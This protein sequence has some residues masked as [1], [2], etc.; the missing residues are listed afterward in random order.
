MLLLPLELRL[1]IIKYLSLRDIC[2]FYQV[3]RACQQ[4][5]VTLVKS[6]PHYCHDRVGLLV[7]MSIRHEIKWILRSIQDWSDKN[8]YFRTC[9][10]YGSNAGLRV[11]F[12][13][14]NLYVKSIDPLSE[15]LSCL[16]ASTLDLLCKHGFVIT[17]RHLLAII[18]PHRTDNFI[19][20]V[21][22]LI[23]NGLSGYIIDHKVLLRIFRLKA[24]NLIPVIGNY[25]HNITDMH[26][27]ED[28]CPYPYAFIYIHLKGFLHP[29]QFARL[30]EYFRE[31]RSDYY[32][33]VDELVYIKTKRRS[34]NIPVEN[35]YRPYKCEIRKR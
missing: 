16:K 15:G 22:Y 20:A 4:S 13:H 32:D 11:F 5:A 18:S 31:R 12:K 24:W 8:N 10:Q 3:S 33:F 21:D 34:R 27:D 2:R 23:E 1:E 28:I 30:F 35:G 25:Y 6:Y 7:N 26:A 17:R 19:Y 29:G 9:I 14:H